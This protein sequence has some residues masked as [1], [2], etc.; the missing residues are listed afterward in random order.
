M[1]SKTAHSDQLSRIRE[2]LDAQYRDWQ[3]CCEQLSAMGDV[4][5]QIPRVRLDEIDEAF[6]SATANTQTFNPAYGARA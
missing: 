4:Q 6:A 3:R 2:E 5:L 1:P